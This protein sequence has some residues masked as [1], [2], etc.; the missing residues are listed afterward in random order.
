MFRTSV[1]EP[2]APVSV[3]SNVYPT[4]YYL[5][6]NCRCYLWQPQ[7]KNESSHLGHPGCSL[8]E[9][10]QVVLSENEEPLLPPG[11][12]LVALLPEKAFPDGRGIDHTA[13]GGLVG[14]TVSGSG[15][16]GV[17]MTCRVEAV[18]TAEVAVNLLEER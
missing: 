8:P 11:E 15:G 13:G 2:T 17:I 6:G 7:L 4:L 12:N 14:N 5:N 3:L 9:A 10:L 1:Q 16:G 18:F